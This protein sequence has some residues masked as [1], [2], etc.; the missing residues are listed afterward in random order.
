L[1]ARIYVTY[2]SEAG[3]PVLVPEEMRETYTMARND[4]RIDG[5]ANYAKFRQFTVTTTEK[6]K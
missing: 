1:S 2:K 6:P 3:L 4:T 5:R